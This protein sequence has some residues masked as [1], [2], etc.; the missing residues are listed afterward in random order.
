[1]SD[2]L[3]LVLISHTLPADWIRSLEG[4]CR[5][6]QGPEE[7]DFLVPKL[8]TLLPEAEGLLSLLTIP[9]SE[10]MLNKAPILKVVSNMAVGYDNVAIAACT[11]RGIPVGNTPGV[12]TEG[13][14][15][16]TMALLL[17][18]ARQLP[19]ASKDA[20][21]GRW[22]T[23][24]PTGWLGSDLHGATLG[25]IGMGKIGMAVAQRA[26]AFG[27]QI[28]FSNPGS[29]P[30]LDPTL[31]AM[32]KPTADVIAEADVLSLHC[33]LTSETKGLIDAQALQAMKSTAILINAARGPVV[34]SQDLV[35]ALR[36]GWIAAAALDVTDPEPLPP[37]HPLYSL[38][39]CL[40]VPHIGSATQHTRKRM[41]E[42]ACNNLLAGL[43]GKPLP[44][45]V[46]P[47][48]YQGQ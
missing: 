26:A 12:L 2:K 37:D 4:S 10:A 5:I 32:R 19:T 25:I 29:K 47:Q 13:T 8:E 11:Q 7:T 41:A 3:P 44:H 28:I 9:V 20:S 35:R 27:M 22:T 42:L 43:K 40:I 23:W 38:D 1:M 34:V 39:N 6:E 17:A 31:L 18:A 15:D 36:Q 46:N 30:D 14:A 45:C 24:S 21:E 33:P 48:V 16:L